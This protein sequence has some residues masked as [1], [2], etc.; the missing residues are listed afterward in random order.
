MLP[1]PAIALGAYHLLQFAM[2]NAHGRSIE[3]LEERLVKKAN[4]TSEH[5]NIGS[6]AEERMTNVREQPWMLRPTTV[7]SYGVPFMLI[8]ALVVQCM[9]LIWR[10]GDDDRTWFWL[11]SALYSSLIVLMVVGAV[12]AFAGLDEGP[13]RAPRPHP[14]GWRAPLS[15]CREARAITAATRYLSVAVLLVGVVCQF[16][17]N[18]DP[19]FP[20][21]YFTVDSALL[22]ASTIVLALMKPES[23]LVARIRGAATLGVVVSGLVYATVIAPNTATGTW[24]QPWD[25]GWVR[26]STVLLHGVGPVL[27]LVYFLLTPYPPDSLRTSL[28]SWLGW[29]ATYIAGAGT[30]AATGIAATPY[31]FLDPETMGGLL[32]LAGSIAATT[33]AITT[34]AMVLYGMR[35]AAGRHGMSGVSTSDGSLAS[36][37]RA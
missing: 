10:L 31:A 33:A 25:D 13:G 6:K 32:G 12:R 14:K 2:V 27:V 34:I 23:V 30:L 19:V 9:D 17:Q 16:L 7:I 8:I 24:F 11:G 4:L 26:T 5:G 21:L 20:L 29:P 37:A 18:T 22:A 28:K 35:V 3:I 1:A 15:S 36:S